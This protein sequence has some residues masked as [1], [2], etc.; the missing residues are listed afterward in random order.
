MTRDTRIERALP[1]ILEDLGAGPQPDYMEDI[2]VRAAS[3]RQRPGWTFP[4]AWLALPGSSGRPVAAP[5]LHWRVILAVGVIALAL[6]AG[7][8]LVSG[9]KPPLPPRTVPSGNGLV[10]YIWRGD[11]YVGDPV[12]GKTTAIVTGP[13]KLGGPR[14]SPDGTRIAFYRWDSTRDIFIEIVVARADGSDERVVQRD[15]P[16]GPGHFA[17][18][19]DSASLVVA[20]D[21]VERS[22]SAPTPPVDFE[23][24][25]VDP[26]GVAEPRLLTPPLPRWPGRQWMDPTAA[27]AQ[28]FRPPAGDLI[29][30]GDSDALNV[31]DP[32]LDSVTELGQ[33]AL[34]DLQPYWVRWPGWS[35]DGSM[36]VFSLDRG[37][38]GW[39]DGQIGT[40]VMNADGSGVRRVGPSGLIAM[41]AWSPNGS[42]IAFEVWR[43][44]KAE[45]VVV[46]VASGAE[47]ALRATSVST[48]GTG[49][50]P[51]GWSWSPDGRS[52][53][54][55]GHE[56]GRPIIVD[57]VTGEATEL[58]WESDSAPSWQRLPLD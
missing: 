50:I 10:A 54:F 42:K 4:E 13:E 52:I 40:F 51:Q 41:S 53:I 22:S 35:P 29:V 30:A 17:W 11:L 47:R 19:P 5:R 32:D 3:M 26:S 9:Q 12:S 7:A 36:I 8:L 55:L 49:R 44:S 56:G 24:S 58:P 21:F 37:E 45:I 34:A 25:I 1:R 23:L 48:T 14:F 31:F 16:G 33:D 38:F 2:L 20:H 39:F 18:T 6:V 15:T 46:D 27:M 43:E 28:M 57:V